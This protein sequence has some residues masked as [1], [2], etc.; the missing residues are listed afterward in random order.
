[1]RNKTYYTNDEIVTDLYTQGKEWMTEDYIEYIGPYHT[2]ITGEVYTEP[3]YNKEFSQKLIEFKEINKDP[4][5]IIYRIL[6]DVKT[7]YNSFNFYQVNITSEDIATGTI[8]RYFIKKINSTNIIEI[9]QTEYDNWSAGT[10]DPNLYE[11][12]SINWCITG[13]LQDTFDKGILI[14]SVST[15]NKKAVDT[16]NKTFKGISAHLNNLIEYYSDTDIVTPKDI[17]NSAI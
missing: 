7:D 13:N 8:N 15:K 4:N 2:Y 16:A 11:A 1:M 6:N 3:T 10:I 12:I 5:N 9:D 14:P 17:N